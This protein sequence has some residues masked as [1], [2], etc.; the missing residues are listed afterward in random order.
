[1]AILTIGLELR[2]GLPCNLVVRVFARGTG[3]QLCHTKDVLNKERLVLPS[4]V[5]ST[6]ELVN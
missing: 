2:R 3:G 5:F 1:M 4:F 6:Y